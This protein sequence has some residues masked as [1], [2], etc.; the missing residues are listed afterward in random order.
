MPVLQCT[1]KRCGRCQACIRSRIRY[2][3]HILFRIEKQLGHQISGDDASVHFD[4]FLER[5]F[6]AS[7][8]L[9]VNFKQFFSDSSLP[10]LGFHQT[11]KLTQ[12]FLENVPC[13]IR[14]L[15]GAWETEQNRDKYWSFVPGVVSHSKFC[16]LEKKMKFVSYLIVCSNVL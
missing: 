16:S 3:T 4:S 1:V 13:M 15:D 9:Y 14:F 5:S 10:H 11:W 2:R 7:L 6:K 8:F 12:V